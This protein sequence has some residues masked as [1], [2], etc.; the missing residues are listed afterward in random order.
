MRNSQVRSGKSSNTLRAPRRN[1]QASKNIASDCRTG[2]ARAGGWV[3]CA[4]ACWR[5]CCTC[6]HRRGRRPCTRSDVN[7][8]HGGVDVVSSIV[9][10]AGDNVVAPSSSSSSGVSL[11]SVHGRD[12]DDRVRIWGNSD[13]GGR[14]R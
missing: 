7:A 11:R 4:A 12:N 13:D 10:S 1:S 8:R 5:R 9:A 3:P 2:R 14:R 6:G